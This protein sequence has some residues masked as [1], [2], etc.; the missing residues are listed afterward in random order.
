MG[1][2]RG[3]K[4]GGSRTAHLKAPAEEA[5][6]EAAPSAAPKPSPW[7]TTRSRQAASATT[8]HQ[9]KHNPNAAPTED[10]DEAEPIEDEEDEEGIDPGAKEVHTEGDHIEQDDEDEEISDMEAE[11]E[12]DQSAAGV[13]HAEGSEELEF[14][15]DVVD[16]LAGM[17]ISQPERWES[18]ATDGTSK[19]APPPPFYSPLCFR[20]ATSLH[21]RWKS[22]KKDGTSS[23]HPPFSLHAPHLACQPVGWKLMTTD[24]TSKHAPVPLTPAVLSLHILSHHDPCFMLLM[25]S[26]CAVHI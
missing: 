15:V 13:T 1:S 26:R 2:F 18:T 24:G 8:S 6:A 11:E 20:H 5:A 14:E 3:G 17:P 22:I 21:E 9:S 10:P 23:S 25:S 19:D 16:A 7:R 4:R 12:E